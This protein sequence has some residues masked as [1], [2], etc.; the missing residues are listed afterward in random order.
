MSGESMYESLPAIAALL[1]VFVI[2]RAVGRAMR[3]RAE[4]RREMRLR[5]HL[6]WTQ[7]L[8]T[9]KKRRFFNI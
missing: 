7:P 5:R 4:T 8:P 9:R 3:E 2:V 1:C 6:N